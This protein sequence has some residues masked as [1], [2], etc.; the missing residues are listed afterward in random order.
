MGK[1]I[2]LV[3]LP[4]SGKS[5]Y[6]KR[7][8]EENS[9]EEVEILSSDTLRKEMFG[10]LCQD[11][12]QELFSEMFKR[13]VSFLK[14]DKTV[15]YDATNISSKRRANLIKQIRSNSS[16]KDTFIECGFI[17]AQYLTCYLNNQKRKDVVPFDVLMRMRNNLQIPMY[18]EGWDSI[19]I[20]KH[21]DCD[22]TIDNSYNIT[23]LFK[24]GARIQNLYEYHNL[25][26]LLW[27]SY[28]KGYNQNNPHHTLPLD[29]HMFKAY[30]YG[31][32][33]K[34]DYVVLMA[35]LF[36]DIGKIFAEEKNDKGYSTYYN[37]ENIS[38]YIFIF[39]GEAIGLEWEQTLKIA[40][41]IQL[42]MQMHDEKR[43]IKLM[44]MLNKDTYIQLEKL[45]ECDINTH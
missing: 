6:A 34:M 22:F 1:L 37:H 12:N 3:G 24:L 10:Y 16:I 43:R 13:T 40:T 20:I 7:Y 21:E 33:H 44:D 28:I 41:L 30:E 42:H 26:D 32:K 36:H 5:T 39:I 19:K 15:I 38:A 9:T 18:Y 11:R 14:E 23:S 27:F 17:Y 35:C 45:H 4:G 2:M 31:V 29:E 25:L 8:K